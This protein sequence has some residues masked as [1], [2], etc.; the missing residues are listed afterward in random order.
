MGLVESQQGTESA[1]PHLTSASSL[2]SPKSS[3]KKTGT[4]TEGTVEPHGWVMGLTPHSFY[5]TPVLWP[6]PSALPQAVTFSLPT[7]FSQT[8]S[9]AEQ[10][11]GSARRE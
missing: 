7:S 4:K 8:S 5:P 3:R 6:A 2:V 9:P 11:W 10:D 1:V